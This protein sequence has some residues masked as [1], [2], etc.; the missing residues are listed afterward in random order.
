MEKV[1]NQ[2]LDEL[3]TL[4]QKVVNIESTQ[5]EHTQLLRALEHRS[6]VTGAEVTTIKE[7]INYLKGD[8]AKNEARHDIV[9]DKLSDTD[10]KLDYALLKIAKHDVKLLAQ[11]KNL[12]R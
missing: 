12:P 1:L 3:K 9:L 6:E 2:I 7:E 10:E 11:K 5:Q 4:N 8:A